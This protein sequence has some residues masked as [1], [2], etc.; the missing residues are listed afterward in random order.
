MDTT[1]KFR[2][3]ALAAVC[4][5]AELVRLIAR[6]DQSPEQLHRVMFNSI[7]MID[8]DTPEQVYG[9]MHDL[10]LGYR[11]LCQQLGNQNEKDID[12]TRYI[13][14]VLTLERKLSSNQR[15]LAELSTQIDELKRSLA[16]FDLLDSNII[17]KMADI[18]SD[19]IGP[20]GRRIEVHG[21]PQY[22]QIQANQHRVRALLLSAIRA[23]VLWRQLGGKRRQLIFSRQAILDVAQHS[24]N[25]L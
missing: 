14:S 17:A 13:V 15:A 16:H 20:L 18:Y 10:S 3:M 11:T 1:L 5:A 19:V 22:L 24:L 21:K 23:A 12:I 2:V 9:Q 8:A 4:Q 6:E 7:T 25:Q